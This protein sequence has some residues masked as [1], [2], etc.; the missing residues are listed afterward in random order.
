MGDQ[1]DESFGSSGN[2]P[3]S[4]YNIVSTLFSRQIKYN[5]NRRLLVFTYTAFQE[6]P[7][8]AFVNNS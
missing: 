1:L 2:L 7:S 4:V 3:F 8:F 5:T 6:T